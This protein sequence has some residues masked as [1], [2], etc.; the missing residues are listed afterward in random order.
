MPQTGIKIFTIQGTGAVFALNLSFAPERICLSWS[1]SAEDKF[2]TVNH[3]GNET[4]VGMN[5]NC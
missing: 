4:N 5:V 1:Y 2:E 3:M